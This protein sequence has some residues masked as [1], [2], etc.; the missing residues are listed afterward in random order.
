MCLK[1]RRL[2]PRLRDPPVTK[3]IRFRK[4]EPPKGRLRK[5]TDQSRERREMLAAQ[6]NRDCP[7]LRRRRVDR[8]VLA[9]ATGR[10]SRNT[11]ERT[12]FKSKDALA[13]ALRRVRDPT[14]P[15]ANEQRLKNAPHGNCGASNVPNRNRTCNLRLR[16]P[17]LY[18]IELWGRG[19]RRG[20]SRLSRSFI[21]IL[22][23]LTS[24]RRGN[25]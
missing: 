13:S 3:H 14:F 21:L 17:T 10:M 22:N 2:D 24:R 6:P 16:R 8:T 9:D 11:L 15:G 23:R 4:I 20:T 5:E 19:D 1:K 18:P 12:R 25:S 7:S